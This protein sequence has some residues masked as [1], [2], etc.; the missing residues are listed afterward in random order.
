MKEFDHT[1]A[2]IRWIV[3]AFLTA[4][5]RFKTF[6]PAWCAVKKLAPNIQQCDHSLERLRMNDDEK[7]REIPV[8][9]EILALHAEV[10]DVELWKL[11]YIVNNYG[12]WGSNQE[13]SS[14]S[15]ATWKFKKFCQQAINRG[16]EDLH[17]AEVVF[18]SITNE[19]YYHKPGTDYDSEEVVEAC[20]KITKLKVLRHSAVNFMVDGKPG[21]P[22]MIGPGHFPNDGSI[23]LKPEQHGCYFKDQYG[24]VCGQSHK[25]HT[26]EMML[27]LD[28]AIDTKQ[29]RKEVHPELLKLKTF[30]EEHNQS[31]P[32]DRIRVDGFGFRPTQ[33]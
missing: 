2:H 4:K 22:F 20:Q 5:E 23:Y 14:T 7:D 12:H 33:K 3:P 17:Q 31:H 13:E 10:G 32:N 6:E 26:H 8:P 1:Q 25:K 24:Q 28:V 19:C 18:Q 11:G 29:Q 9:P 30:I 27:L 21:H 15:G 16:G